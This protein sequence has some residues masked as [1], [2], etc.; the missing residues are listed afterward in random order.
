MSD[1]NAKSGSKVWFITGSSRGFG[2]VWADAALKRGD[3]VAATARNLD[4]IADLKEKYG[5]NVLTLEL[6]VTNTTQVKSAVEQAH[7]HFGRLDIVLNNAG[8]SLVATIEEATSDDVK[9]MYETNIF[10]PLAVIQAALPL[11]RKQG[12]GHILGTSSNLGH[13]TLPVIGYYA[14]SKWA[15]EAI[16]ESLAIEVAAFG[17]KVT[18]I[19]PGA[20]ATE[21]GSQESLK[22]SEG[23]DIY[24]DFKNQFFGSLGELKRGDPNAT[25]DAVFKVVDAENPPLRFFLGSECLPWVKK[26]YGERLAEWEQWGDVSN[27]AQG[28]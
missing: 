10:G 3:R 12:Y 28:N 17:I 23:M 24:T 16:H 20:Y 8:Y 27:S 2:R 21:F 22:F 26:A 4:S 18:I 19:E 5:D 1:T 14:S 9:A 11:L 25:P 6:D 7:A 13:V 15:F